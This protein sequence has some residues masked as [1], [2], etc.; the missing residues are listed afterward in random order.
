MILEWAIKAVETEGARDS[1][2]TDYCLVGK[3]LD[4]LELNNLGA[5][6]GTP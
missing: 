6:R 4:Y 2:N 3:N 5:P 1:K